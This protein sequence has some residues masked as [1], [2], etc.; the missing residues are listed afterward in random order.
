[1]KLVEKGVAQKEPRFINRA[2]RNLHSLRRKTNDTVLRAVVMAYYPPGK[3]R[4]GLLPPP[5][6]PPPGG[7][8][9]DLEFAP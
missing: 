5:P 4:D 9:R 2:I 6:P 3:S 8:S 7:K 1:M